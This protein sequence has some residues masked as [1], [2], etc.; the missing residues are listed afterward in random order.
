MSPQRPLALKPA[1]AGPVFRPAFGVLQRKCACGSSGSPEGACED[2]K[3]KE[4]SLQR[5]ASATEGPRADAGVRPTAPPI[6]HEVL[7]S[8]GRPLDAATRA[9]MEP[10][11]GHD[12]SKVRVHADAEAAASARAVNAL[13]YTVGNHVVFAAGR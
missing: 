13:A 4:M 11:F 10:R 7:R 3:Q 2:C 12:F 8:P 1:S 5:R 9:F 6:V